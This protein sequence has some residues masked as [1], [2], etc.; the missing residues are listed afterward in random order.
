MRSVSPPRCSSSFQRLKRKRNNKL[1]GS[2]IDWEVAKPIIWKMT[3][4]SW[5]SLRMWNWGISLSQRSAGCV[6]DRKL[7]IAWPISWTCQMQEWTTHKGK[8]F[9]GSDINLKSRLSNSVKQQPILNVY[10]KAPFPDTNK[11]T[12]G[13]R[14]HNRSISFSWW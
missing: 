1:S 2:P 9:G 14:H 6:P 8:A 5:L 3:P 7:S 4:P 10:M 11:T 13:L 12:S